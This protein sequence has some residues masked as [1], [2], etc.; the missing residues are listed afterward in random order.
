MSGMKPKERLLSL[1]YAGLCLKFC[2]ELS[3]RKSAGLMNAVFHR[4][5]ERSVK[6]RTLS[7]WAENCGNRISACLKAVSDEILK[8][9]RFDPETGLPEEDS[10]V[11]GMAAEAANSIWTQSEREA[12]TAEIAE[13]AAA[14]NADREPAARIKDIG[15][16]PAIEVSESKSCYISIDDIGVNKQ[17][18]TRKDGGSK[19]G[20]RVENTVIH[21]QANGR[22]HCLT[23]I[24][25]DNAFKTLLAFL[26]S[27]G[28][29]GSHRLVFFA[30][31]ATSIKNGIE[32]YFSFCPYIQ[33]L[34]WYHLRKKCRELISS[35]V[36]GTKEQKNEI[37]KCLLRMLWVGNADEAIDYLGGLDRNQV[38]SDYWLGELMGYLER[39]K[40]LI[41]CY[42]LRYKLGLRISSNRVEKANDMLVAERQKHNGMSW[43]SDGSGALAAI[44]MVL[45]NGEADRWL[46]S[47]TLG[48]HMGEKAA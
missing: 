31:G 37:I 47:H 27:N 26:V 33:V 11:R 4:S 24:G 6:V 41:A 15:R 1:A 13:T 20:K 42:A 29:P 39:K 28:L 32:K 35:A 21:I 48:F 2:S 16:L 22:S 36:K 10:P 34:D 5:G 18:E 46:R 8:D 19:N 14:F 9:N 44:S 45:L 3:Y 23:A 40:P 25:M 17:K 7:D 30:D 43:S 12:R 38:K